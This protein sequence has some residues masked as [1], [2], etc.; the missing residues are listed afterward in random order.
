[1]DGNRNVMF[2]TERARYCGYRPPMCGDLFL[3]KIGGQEDVNIRLRVKIAAGVRAVQNRVMDTALQNRIAG[4]ID[5][6]Q[7]LKRL[8]AYTY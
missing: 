7:N 2:Q 3:R 8:I 6:F 4:T 1:M 5:R